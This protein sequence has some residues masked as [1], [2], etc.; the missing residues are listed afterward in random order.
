MSDNNSPLTTTTEESKITPT[1]L[2]YHTRSHKHVKFFT[3]IFIFK[4]QYIKMK[5]II[6]II[7]QHTPK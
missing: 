6:K 7:L 4:Y 1:R 5:L 3:Y 2:L